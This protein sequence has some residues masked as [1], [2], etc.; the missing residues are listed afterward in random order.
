MR[1]LCA[2]HVEAAQNWPE[3]FVDAHGAITLERVRDQSDRDRK[4]AEELALHPTAAP[5]CD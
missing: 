1:T 3:D 4:L 5:C 2:H